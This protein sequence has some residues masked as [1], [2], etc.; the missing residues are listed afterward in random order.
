MTS[1]RLHI[2]YYILESFFLGIGFFIIYSLSFTYQIPALITLL[3]AYSIVGVTHHALRHDIHLK[4]VLEYIFIS[5]LTFAL[6]MFLKSG[7]V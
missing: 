6:F 3:L 2:N 5:L 7:I 4:I 1:K